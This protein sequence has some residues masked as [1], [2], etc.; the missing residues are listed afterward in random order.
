MAKILAVDLGSSQLKLLLME[1]SGQV[2][3]VV[4]AVYPTVSPR[5]GWLE[6]NPSDWE[7]ALAKGFQKLAEKAE[8]KEISVISFS[9]H[10]SGIVPLGESGRALYPCIMLSDIRSQKEC[11]EIEKA[12]GEM[13]RKRTGNPVINAFSLPKLLWL[14][15]H[16]PEIYRRMK[17]WI[18]PKDYIRFLFTDKIGTEYTDAY[19]AICVDDKEKQ[20]IGEIIQRLGLEKEKFPEIHKPYEMAGTVTKEASRRYGICEGIPVV[21][22][23]ADMACGAVGNG[24][25]S[26]GDATLTLGT[27]ATFLAMVP[28]HR[29]EG[30][31]KITY[32]M[33]VQEGR[34]YALGSHFNGGLAVNWI[35]QTLSEEEKIDY[36]MIQRLSKKAADVLPG[37]NGIMTLPFLNGSG[38]PYFYAGDRQT[39]LGISSASTRAEIFRSQ[40]EGV[41]YNLRESLELFEKILGG[42]LKEVV[43]GGGGIRIELWPR[44]IAD[45]FGRTIDLCEHADSS[46]I[47]AA[48]VGGY[49]VG[50]F[51]SMENISRK[52]LLIQK[53]L[54]PDE[55]AK[56]QYDIFYERYVRTYQLLTE[57]YGKLTERGMRF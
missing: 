35:S 16:E 51:E 20:W 8:L 3:A 34:F 54:V 27:C 39:V 50:M 22:G 56:K 28:E 17:T 11:E 38:S 57:Y 49:G 24:L 9:G 15:N 37:S 18:A 55:K 32:H 42:R 4:T 30:F 31:G 10:M 45:I 21:F 5:P 44:L 12:A 14:K 2:S 26:Y 33:H 48:L 52:T 43:L 6:Q 53:R 13:I 23:A 25:F 41:T 7:D 46:A 1:E 47:G 40:L 29:E 19:N 36:E